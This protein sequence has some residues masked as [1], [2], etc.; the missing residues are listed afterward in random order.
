ALIIVISSAPFTSADCH[1][2]EVEVDNQRRQ[3]SCDH[4]QLYECKDFLKE[5]ERRNMR[6]KRRG[7]LPCAAKVCQECLNDVAATPFNNYSTKLRKKLTVL[8][9]IDVQ[10]GKESVNDKSSSS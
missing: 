1:E 8:I 4:R 6:R 10:E 3:Q 9:I 5:E 2:S 7:R